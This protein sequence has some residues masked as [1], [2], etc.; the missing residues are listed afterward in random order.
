MRKVGNVMEVKRCMSCMQEIS[1]S[2]CEYC[3]Y[4]INTAAKN[5]MA[6]KPE[7]LLHGRYLVGK[8]LGQG[9]FGITYVGFDLVL[10]IKV[11]IKEYFPAG[12]ASRDH[13]ITNNLQ[14]TSVQMENDNWR[15]G[16]EH[17]LKEARRMAKIDSIPSIVRVRDTFFENETAYIIM[18]F[19]EGITLKS[20]LLQNGPMTFSQCIGVMN[21]LLQG[22]HSIHR[23]NLI[24][25]D[26]SPDNIM[27]QPDGTVK[28]LD[29]GAA[30]DM[31]SMREGVSQMV[32]KKGFSPP[33]QYMEHGQIGSWTD[34]YSLTATIYY[35]I[36]GKVTPDAM[37]RV[38]NDPLTFDVPM[39]EAITP[40]VVDVLARGLA[41]K[42]ENRI[43]TAEDLM[44]QLNATFYDSDAT[45]MQ[46]TYMN[47]Q[48]NFDTDISE[49]GDGKTRTKKRKKNGQGKKGKIKWIIAVSVLAVVL[50]AGGITLAVL[51][52]WRVYV[53]VLGTSNSNVL[54][55]G[56]FVMLP[57]EYEYFMDHNNVLYKCTYDAQD[58]TFYVDEAEAVAT[59]V[60][61]LTADSDTIYYINTQD[62]NK[63]SICGMD[64]AGDEE[65]VLYDGTNAI[66]F[67][68]YAKLS[69]KDEYLYFLEY[70]NESDGYVEYY[71]YRY[72]LEKKSAEA[73]IKEDV[74]WYNVYGEYIYYTCIH[75]GEVQLRRAK[76][77]GKK[78]EVLCEG[79]TFAYG[80]VEDDRI[81][82]YSIDD[83]AIIVM[84]LDGKETGGIY[85]INMDV[86]YFTFAYGDDWIYYMNAEDGAIHRIRS[87]NS[88]DEVVL[89]DHYAIS[90]CFSNDCIWFS[91]AMY[92][93]DE[94]TMTRAYVMNKDGTGLIALT[95]ADMRTTSSGLQ[96]KLSGN[97]AIICGYVGDSDD[98][99]I[100]LVMDGYVVTDIEE[101]AL[102]SGHHYF[103]IEDES[104]F[105]YHVNE[106]GTGVVIDGYTGDTT[107]LMIPETIGGLPV[108]AIGEEAFVDTEIEQIA[109]PSG[110]LTVE[111]NAFKEVETLAYVGLN[112]GLVSVE[113]FAFDGCH[114]LTDVTL[115][116]SIETIEACA[117][118]RTSVTE[119]Y[120]PANVSFIGQW[121]FDSCEKLSISPDNPYYYADIYNT[122]F[123]KDGKTLVAL[124]GAWD[125]PYL[126]PNGVEVIGEYAFSF[127][128]GI[129][130]VTLSPS[131]TTIEDNAFYNCSSL[132]YVD[133]PRSVM[134]IGESAFESCPLLT[135]ITVSPECVVNTIGNE[136]IEI[137]DFQ[138]EGDG[139]VPRE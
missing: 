113:S 48:N 36:T 102:P 14:W 103:I 132:S 97:E 85:D 72:N 80:F 11:A 112:E 88:G 58:G 28:L 52:P 61:Y 57:G 50:M 126:V 12:N 68:Q 31:E 74:I 21:P 114:I 127:T 116:E 69:N 17:F 66:A 1:G 59:N 63:Y 129:T 6:L 23:H 16:C 101:N 122:I 105:E 99:G 104:V 81:Y 10:N 60:C 33:E 134:S 35:C 22:L 95:D 78:P 135:R 27:L 51:K 133:I 62:E 3:G 110:L 5:T 39:R 55:D 65:E 19:V 45:Y 94:M 91:E 123:T 37:D 41:V 111:K 76:L 70:G 87:N 7:S 29:F 138:S 46:Q 38:M 34:V 109:F 44:N 18:D 15:E 73:V 49:Q 121:A 128:E 96:Y 106:D 13:N 125:G 115:P 77:N 90:I 9:G 139:S 82:L 42:V 67:L 56:G 79:E 54:N 130:Q 47:M 84:D 53:E 136:E 131:V 43:Q 71:I 75:D 137:Y 117:F 93:D 4:D 107:W 120:I 98:V 86:S 64:F 30:K 2:V 119:V 25:R 32:T 118:D 108:V 92:V 40:Q 100:P 89:N 20:Y 124:V 8:M 24:H 83:K 26:I